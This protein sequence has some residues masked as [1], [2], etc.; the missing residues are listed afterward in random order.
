MKTMCVLC[1]VRFE[2]MYTLPGFC[3]PTQNVSDRV[4]LPC[5]E[6]CSFLVVMQTTDLDALVLS[7]NFEIT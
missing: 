5:Y 1:E 2:L 6:I 7:V 4:A 3:S